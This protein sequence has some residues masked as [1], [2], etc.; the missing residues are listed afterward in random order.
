MEVTVLEGR[1]AR[2]GART[3]E[4]PGVVPARPRAVEDTPAPHAAVGGREYRPF[5]EREAADVFIVDVPWNGLAESVKIASMADAYEINVA[6][7]NFYSHL[8]TMMSA[9]FSAVV[10][11]LRIMEIDPDMVPWQDDLVTVQPQISDGYLQIPTGPG[12]G[13]EVDEAAVRA[14]PPKSR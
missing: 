6:P 8:A 2:S 9:H 10:P 1:S 13:T 7:H 14:H 11:N 5:F 12:W 4:L 3:D